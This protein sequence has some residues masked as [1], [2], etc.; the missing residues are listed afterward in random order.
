MKGGMNMKLRYLFFFLILVSL[1]NFSTGQ[2]YIKLDPQSQQIDY[3]PGQILVKFKD[4]VIISSET[5]EKFAKVNIASIDEIFQE[6]KIYKVTKLFRG[7][8]RLLKPK[9]L[10]SFSGETFLQ[11]NLHNIYKLELKDPNQMFEAIERLKKDQNVE[12]AEP[13]YIFSVVDAKPV[14]DVLSE[15]DLK[16]YQKVSTPNQ[17]TGLVPNDPLYSQQWYIPA[18]HADAVWNSTTGDTTQ[19]IGVLDTGVDWL[20]PDLANNIWVNYSELNGIPGIDDDR[21]GFIDDIHGWDFINNDNDPRDDNS[22]GTHVAGIISAVGNNGIGIAGVNWHAKI[23][24]I[25]VFQSSGRG[26]VATITQGIWYAINK[27]ATILNMSFGSYARSLTMENAL[28][29]AY[30][31]AVL[32]AAAGNDSRNIGPPTVLDPLAQPFFPAAYSFVLGV[33]AGDSPPPLGFS[34]WDPDGPV[35]SGFPELFNYELRAPGVGILST[36]PNGNYRLF[37]GTSMSTALVSGAISLYR[38]IYPDQ[39]QELIWGNLINTT[40]YNIDLLASLQAQA[41]PVLWFVSYTLVDTLNGDRDGRPDAGEIIELW[42]R[43]RNTWKRADSVFVG[44]RFGEFEDSAIAQIIKSTGFVGNIGPY[45]TGSNEMDVLKIRLG[46][47]VSNGRDIEFIALLWSANSVDTIRQRITLT[48]ENG[49]EL[50]GVMDST[51][52]LTP[53]KFWIV[54]GPFR[55]GA[56]GRLVLRPGTH[57]KL[58]NDV[59]VRGEVEAI[60]SPDS[61]IIIEGPGSFGGWWNWYGRGLFKYVNFRDQRSG[62][63]GDTLEYCVIENF[64]TQHNLNI[65]NS[66]RLIRN[67]I[68]R[69]CTVDNGIG[70]AQHIRNNY[71][72]LALRASWD[73]TASGCGSVWLF[74]NFAKMRLYSGSGRFFGAFSY[75]PTGIQ[76]NYLSFQDG[77]AVIAAD[78]WREVINFPNQYWG[79]T[80]SIKIRKM[81][82]DFWWGAGGNAPVMNIY[83]ILTAPLDSAH[84]CVWKVLVNGKDAQDEIVDPVGVGPVRFDVY[85]NRPMDTTYTPQLSFGVREPY[86]QNFVRDSARWSPDGRIWTAYTTIKINTGDGINRIRVAGA[87]DPEGFEIPVEDTRFNFIISAAASASAGFS[88]TPG[89]GKITLQWEKPELTDILGFN[90]YRFTNITDTT[91]SQPQL[92]NTT[93]ILDTFYTDFNVIPNKRYYYYYKI[94]RTNFSETD[95]SKVV[96]AIPF[97]STKGDV[98][99]DLT[100]NV[101]DVV[102][103][104]SYILGQNPQPFI[105]EAADV[106]NDSL[107]NILDIVGIINII[108]NTNVQTMSLTSSNAK[109][110][111][112]NDRLELTTDVPISGIQFQLEGQ[113]VQKLKFIQQGV[114]SNFEIVNGMHG[115]STRIYLIFNLNGSTLPIG[116]YTLG[117]FQEMQP[118]IQLTKA[119]LSDPTGKNVIT[120]VYNNGS[121]LIPTEYY[122]N[123]NYPNPFNSTTTIEFGLPEK[124][125]VTITI[126]NVLGQLVRE[127]RLGEMNPGRYKIQWDGR[128]QMGNIVASGVYF[129]RMHTP[130][131]TKVR[132]LVL[133]K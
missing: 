79:T 94:V 41:H 1:T 44:I 106:N 77:F 4:D 93:L 105:F 35:Y 133:I 127:Y 26:D 131:F 23:M 25:K 69:N 37:S 108:L 66:V 32:V 125:D 18:I 34:N 65:F 6:F 132:K 42:F 5:A 8:K 78:G 47:T 97:T 49:F 118:N 68:I 121:P 51:L 110:E 20:H 88:A 10:K 21:N 109:L 126:Y 15:D 27:G 38:A 54:N 120:S 36:I 90:L 64:F 71:Y 100:V 122:L 3:V 14:S 33:Q 46:S 7:A 19:I 22:H 59:V 113:N 9:T 11:P 117:T 92:I 98:N 58:Y 60:G 87:R 16:S 81:Y 107:I 61:L 119:I 76:N 13:N 31:H 28:A 55:V 2:D 112:I 48:V 99:G 82:H 43:V 63:N 12:Y 73:C 114:L 102:A 75:D 52:V 29:Y 96:S 130:Q 123:Q 62:I 67:S 40:S 45:A 53:D 91:F 83:P 70:G 89:L 101:L 17:A 80:D 104:V 115:D 39:P 124:T 84:G 56:N 85:F 86:T 95:S 111:L 129:Y 72:N 74:N 24:P 57:I 128:N 50:V 103:T 116:R 30:A